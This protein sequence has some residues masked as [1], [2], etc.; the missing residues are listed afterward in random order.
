MLASSSLAVCFHQGRSQMTYP[1]GSLSGVID[2]ATGSAAVPQGRHLTFKPCGR[3]SGGRGLGSR[4]QDL[5][6]QPIGALAFALEIRAMTGHACLEPR[7][8]RLQC[9]GLCHQQG[10]VGRPAI[11]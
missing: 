1:A 7:D 3:L 4:L 5:D 11:V 9:L 6:H 2:R 10:N 8:L